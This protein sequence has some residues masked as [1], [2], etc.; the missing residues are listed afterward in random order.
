MGDILKEI[1]DIKLKQLLDKYNMRGHMY[2]EYPHKDVWSKEFNDD[3]YRKALQHLFSYKKN[4]PLL[5]YVHIPFCPKQCLFCIC[6]SKVT[7][8]YER[9]KRYLGYLFRE[10]DLLKEYFDD[11][12]ITPTFTDI[13][14]GGGSPT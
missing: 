12:K 10:I 7:R 13:H 6:Y 11:N 9:V 4:V 5:L 14:L 1:G 8:N 2:V 3:D